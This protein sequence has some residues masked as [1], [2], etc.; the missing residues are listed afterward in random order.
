M[1][2]TMTAPEIGQSRKL[3]VRVALVL[4]YDGTDYFGFQW[5]TNGRSIQGAVEEA[6]EKLTGEKTRVLGSS[7][8]DAGVHALCQIAHLEVKTM[9]APEIIRMKFNDELPHDICIIEVEKANQKYNFFHT[10]KILKFNTY[11]Y[12][13]RE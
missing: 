11:A 9:L 2:L 1:T 13:C 6:L 4:E 5:Q 12:T 3:T 10:I 7:R 8:T